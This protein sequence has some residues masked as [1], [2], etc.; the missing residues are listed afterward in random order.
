MLSNYIIQLSKT[1]KRTEKEAILKS[2]VAA[3]TLGSYSEK[4]FL[5]L[6]QLCY[7]P[8]VTFGVRGDQVKPTKFVESSDFTR[9]DSL[10]TS[11]STRELTGNNAINAIRNFAETCLSQQDW[12]W[13]VKPLLNRD[14][15]CGV[16]VATFNK[17]VTGDF[18]INEFNC[19]LAT[20]VDKIEPEQLKGKFALEVKLDG[21]RAIS[22]IRPLV[23]NPLLPSDI[24]VV[25]Y[26]RV[27]KVFE[28]FEQIESQLKLV[29]L[30][31]FRN[32]HSS[33]IMIDGEIIGQSFQELMTHARRKHDK[34][35]SGCVFHA[36]DICSYSDWISENNGQSQLERSIRLKQL[37][38][39]AKIK[40]PE[41][42]NIGI[43]PQLEV[44]DLSSALGQSILKQFAT[45]AVA[46]GFEGCMIKKLDRPYEF[47][48]TKHWLKWK[49]IITVDL[50]IVEVEQGT[51]KYSDVM[52]ALVC[53]GIDDEKHIKVN[54]GSGFSDSQRTE[55]WNARNQLIGQTVEIIADTITKESGS[56]TYS[57]RFPRFKCFR[58]DK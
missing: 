2:I 20:S 18:K 16:N 5:H 39:C 45:E 13:L 21:V 58:D 1:T 31:E 34:Q 35:E 25:I 8:Y 42:S 54:V 48:R 50:K 44:D 36:F 38:N 17:V 28:N 46:Q 33:G 27:G 47:K 43:V 14:M 22:L 23:E 53:E 41:I 56:D 15:R 55:F 40:F 52:G 29:G 3:S 30:T 12:E 19:Q 4:L 6:F 11:L 9:L 26:S 57:L 24:Q 37:V 32:S 10:L 7:N 51:G 49:P